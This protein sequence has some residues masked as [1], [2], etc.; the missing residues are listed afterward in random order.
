MNSKATLF[1]TRRLKTTLLWTTVLGGT[2]GFIGCAQVLGT[3]DYEED[4]DAFEPDASVAV[5]T[6]DTTTE[7]TDASEAESTDTG[8]TEA[9]DVSG[10][11]TDA[12]GPDAMPPPSNS[13]GGTP[14]PTAPDPST[15][16]SQ[17]A[18][19]GMGGMPAAGGSD[20]TGTAGAGGSPANTGGMPAAGGSGGTPE[21][22]DPPVPGPCDTLSQCG[23]GDGE[24]CIVVNTTTGATACVAEG[25]SAPYSPCADSTDCQLGYGCV[26]GVC[27]EYCDPEETPTCNQGVYAACTPVTAGGTE[28]PEYAVC[29]RTCDPL[30]P[31][32][33]DGP[34]EACGE[35]VNCI[36][37]P[38][39]VSACV[40]SNGNS[41]QDESCEGPTGA[42]DP[43][44]CD[45]GFACVTVDSDSTC[46]QHC[47][48][49]VTDCPVGYRCTSYQPSQGATTRDFGF[50]DL[51]PNTTADSCDPVSQCGCPAGEMCSIVDFDSGEVGCVSEGGI[52]SGASCGASVGE[53]EPGADCM[54]WLDTGVCS[55]FCETDADCPNG[56]PCVEWEAPDVKQCLF[57]C[58]PRNPQSNSGPFNG[59]QAG[60]SCTIWTD[61]PDS[62]VCLT[63]TVSAPEGATCSSEDT[64]GPGLTCVGLD[65]SGVCEPWCELGGNDCPSGEE[66][67]PHP[68]LSQFLSPISLGGVDYGTCLPPQFEG[69]NTTAEAIP[70]GSANGDWGSVVST[71]TVSG[72][73]FPVGKVVVEVD[74]SHSWIGDIII[75]LEAPD[76]TFI[77]LFDSDYLSADNE[78]GQNM[79][80]AIFDDDA[81]TLVT[82]GTAPYSGTFRPSESLGTFEGFDANG[83]WDLVIFD[84]E[85]LITGTLN[86]WSLTI[87]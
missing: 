59:C 65:A 55:P 8:A 1:A 74:I 2:V 64:C 39:G 3:G 38:G 51:C 78:Q 87:Y 43:K 15:N 10:D 35:G 36:P 49:G 4:P 79:N 32:R 84:D 13:D 54:R 56:Q 67:V 53:C 71:L 26:A 66:C 37:G 58:D 47:E 73:T 76:D 80:G 46:K 16:P 34:Y 28:V 82:E 57:G 18:T 60:Q 85:Q 33:S 50:C 9:T 75:V 44:L 40:A 63:P 19:G 70:D 68:Y 42:A 22:C 11:E 27:K 23:C 21:A 77:V 20:G 61:V 24:M 52:S 5:D 17:E 6:D 29:L 81:T 30:D 72:T 86:S 83:D 12:M 69:A 62:S 48:L 45:T 7:T 14:S 31:T 41:T 25:D